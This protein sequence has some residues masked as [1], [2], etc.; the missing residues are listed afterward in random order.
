MPP[1]LCDHYRIVT[2]PGYLYT[3]ALENVNMNILD[4]GN[5]M[6]CPQFTLTDNFKVRLTG[7]CVLCG[8]WL[9]FYM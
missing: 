3:L 1:Q 4:L 5:A 9:P 6:A 8:T 7:L 2:A